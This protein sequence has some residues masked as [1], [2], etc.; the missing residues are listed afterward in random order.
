MNLPIVF[1]ISTIF[2]SFNFLQAEPLIRLSKEK[3]LKGEPLYLELE[4]KGKP[5]LEIPQKVITQSNVTLEY[6]GSQDNL[7]IING[8]V[9]QER[10]LKFR[11]VTSKDGKLQ[12]PPFTILENGSPIPIPSKAFEVSKQRYVHEPQ[13]LD[14]FDSIFNRMLGPQKRQGDT[15]NPTDSHILFKVNKQRAYVGETLVGYYLFYLRNMNGWFLER[16]QQSNPEFPFFTSE[17]LPNVN[18]EAPS[19]DEYKGITYNL[20][21]YQREVYA[22][23]PL[24]KG[25]YKIGK[26]NFLLVD[27]GLESIFSQKS[28]DA[29]PIEITVLD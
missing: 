12:T 17:L 3:V 26:T 28:I 19:T 4:F 20:F 14:D 13:N 1:L 15:Y 11:V 22:L 21:P 27:G 24:R 16:N 10:T 23:T 25:K 5:N 9:S 2:L 7:S 6:L 18:I 29:E 8:K